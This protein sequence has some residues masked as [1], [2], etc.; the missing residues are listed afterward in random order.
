MWLRAAINGLVSAAIVVVGGATAIVQSLPLP[1]PRSVGLIGRSKALI[2][3]LSH[4][5]HARF[6]NRWRWQRL[7]VAVCRQRTRCPGCDCAGVGQG[8]AGASPHPW[9]VVILRFFDW[10]SSLG[11]GIDRAVCSLRRLRRLEWRVMDFAVDFS[12]W[13]VS[14][15]GRVMLTHGDKS[16]SCRERRFQ[17]RMVL[18]VVVTLIKD[19]ERR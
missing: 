9:I 15:G 5:L 10:S 16:S 8:G 18:I 13:I 12:Q 11:S 6:S 4:H 17:L 7:R 3:V 2:A 1:R 14:A 19:W